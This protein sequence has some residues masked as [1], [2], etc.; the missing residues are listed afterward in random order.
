[1]R[2]LSSTLQ[3]ATAWLLAMGMTLSA[4][5]PTTAYADTETSDAAVEVTSNT[6]TG[7]NGYASIDIQANKDDTSILE[8]KTSNSK[9]TDQ[10]IRL[11]LWEFDEGFFEDYEFTKTPEKNVTIKDINDTKT[12]EVKTKTG[13]NISLEYSIDEENSDYYISFTLEAQSEYEFDINFENISSDTDAIDFV[14]EPEIM[15]A[16]EGDKASD[17]AKL[18]TISDMDS[19]EKSSETNNQSS[20]D[21]ESEKKDPETVKSEEAQSNNTNNLAENNENK[22]G[23]NAYWSLEE[24]EN[25]S[26]TLVISGSGPMYDY[27]L[28]SSEDSFGC[29]S[30]APWCKLQYKNNIA[31]IIIED[32]ITY[33]GDNSF[34]ALLIN[35][36]VI[37]DSVTEIGENVFFA[38]LLDN[39]TL[40]FIGRSQNDKTGYESTFGYLYG[41]MSKNAEIIGIPE[42]QLPN[43]CQKVYHTYEGYTADNFDATNDDAYTYIYNFSYLSSITITKQTEFSDFAFSGINGSTQFNL[44][45]NTSKYSNYM[46][47]SG[48]LSGNLSIPSSVELAPHALAGISVKYLDFSAN[49]SIDTFTH[50]L[51]EGTKTQVLTLPKSLKKI[52]GEGKTFD[53]SDEEG[54][55]FLLTPDLKQFYELD[56]IN[57][58]KNFSSAFYIDDL[59]EVSNKDTD[60][61]RVVDKGVPE[62]TIRIGDNNLNDS[63]IV[64]ITLPNSIV[65]IGENAFKDCKQLQAINLDMVTSIGE[66][67]FAGCVA[68]NY[69][70]LN[71]VLEDIRKETF[72]GCTSLSNIKLPEEIAVIDDGSFY[73]CISLTSIDLPQSVQIIG[74]NAFRGTGLSSVEIPTNVQQIRD[75]AFSNSLSLI[76]VNG[77]NT[78][79]EVRNSLPNTMIADN[80]FYNTGLITNERS[81]GKLFTVEKDGLSV[82]VETDESKNRTPS[83]DDV[84]RLLYYTG[85]TASTNI[86]ISNPNGAVKQSD[87][88]RVLLNSS[89]TYNINMDEGEFNIA[90]GSNNYT[91]K[92]TKT[93]N[94]YTIE[95]EA[96]S[97]G[98]TISF[99][100]GSSFASG[101]TGG[102]L[103]LISAEI[104]SEDGSSQTSEGA[105][106]LSWGTHPDTYPV[107]KQMRDTWSLTGSGNNDGISYI[108]GLSYTIS[109]A[110]SGDTLEGIGEDPITSLTFTDTLSIPEG[111][112]ISDEIKT[113][114]NNGELTYNDKEV[115]FN[116]RTVLQITTDNSIHIESI[117][118]SEDE[119]KLI[120]KW[121]SASAKAYEYILTYGNRIFTTNTKLAENQ[122]IDI[123]NDIAVK[124]S[125]TYSAPQNQ[126]SSV[127]AS[128]T[129]SAGSID[130]SY[131][132][133]INTY[134]SGDVTLNKAFAMGTD[135]PYIITLHNPGITSTYVGELS[136]TLPRQFYISSEGIESMFN[137]NTGDVLEITITNG[138]ITT[139]NSIYDVTGYDGGSYKSTIDDTWSGSQYEGLSQPSKDSYT[140]DYAS[141][142]G[143]TITINKGNDCLIMDYD[144]QKFTIGENGYYKTVEEAF[145]AINFKNTYYTQYSLVWDF[146]N[147]AKEIYSGETITIDIPATAKSSFMMLTK[148]ALGQYNTD[149]PYISSALPCP[150][151][152]STAQLKYANGNDYYKTASV[153]NLYYYMD[154]SINLEMYEDGE[155]V[156]GDEAI[157]EGTVSEYRNYI[158]L[159][160]N[161]KM[162]QIPLVN[163]L[164]SSQVVMV[165]VKENSDADWAADAEIFTAED[166]VQYY[167]I[168]KEGTYEDVY[169][170]QLLSYYGDGYNDAIYKKPLNHSV[171]IAD[172][173][174]VEETGSGLKTTVYWYIEKLEQI[175]YEPME[176]KPGFV[177]YPDALILCYHVLN[178][179]KYNEQN[180]RYY[181][182]TAYLGDYQGHRLVDSFGGV[183]FDIEKN[184]VSEIGDTET[185]S[186][187]SVIGS[188]DTVTYRLS[189][190]STTDHISTVTGSEM[191]DIL[192]LSIDSYRWTKDNV[193]I[194]YSGFES[195]SDTTEN[196][197]TI[198][199]AQGNT[200]QQNIKW[201]DDFKVSFNSP[202][203]IWVTLKYPD[204]TAWEQYLN[205]YS[206]ANLT[207]TFKVDGP[208]N[209]QNTVS[210][211][212]KQ[213]TEVLLQKGVYATGSISDFSNTG[214]KA[215]VKLK[216]NTGSQT[217]YYYPN[218]TSDKAFVAYYVVLYNQG[219]S[220]LYLTD[221]TDTLPEGYTF[222][223]VATSRL[224]KNTM[225]NGGYFTY[226][227]SIMTSNSSLYSVTPNSDN[228]TFATITD[229]QNSA[230]KY[231]PARI[232]TVQSDDNKIT[233][234]FPHN[235]GDNNVASYDEAVGLSY[236]KPGES[237]QFAY[238]CSTDSYDKTQDI[239]NN[240]IAMPIYNRTGGNISI[241][242]SEINVY[243][244]GADANDGG[245]SLISGEE[246]LTK[247]FTDEA[248]DTQWV[249]SDVNV[250]RGGIKPGLSKK[251]VS[252]ESPSA[253]VTNNPIIVNPTDTL[254]WNVT[255]YNSGTN[256]IVD[257]TITDELPSP[258]IFSGD[259]YYNIYG[260]AD[261]V[262]A[263]PLTS[264][265]TELPLFTITN[266]EVDDSG[267][268]ESMTIQYTSA[269]GNRVETELTVGEETINA[270]I[271]WNYRHNGTTSDGSYD[272]T[273]DADYRIGAYYNDKG[274]L[275][276]SVEF[277]GDAMGIPTNGYGVLTLHTKNSTNTYINKTYTNTAYVTPNIQTWDGQV[278]IGNYEESG[279]TEALVDLPSVRNSAPFTVANGYA[280]TSTKS[281]TDNENPTNT[282]TSNSDKNYIVL[283]DATKEFT[284][285]LSVDNVSD[286]TMDKLILIDNLPQVG[287]HD[288]F[289]PEEERESEF[290]VSLSEN[291][292]FVVTVAPDSSSA[293]W[294][295]HTLNS[296]QY[297]IQYSTKTEFNTDD[298][299][300]T[301]TGWTTYQEGAD[302]SEAR[303]IRLI[304]LDDEGTLIPANS[305]VRLSFT[306]K[307]D[308]SAKAGEY[309]WNSF[310]YHYSMYNSELELEA[311]P[312]EVG[313]AIIGKPSIIKNVIDTNGNPST[314]D[315]DATYR[316]ILYKGHY[317]SD[318]DDSSSLKDVA[319][320]LTEKGIEFSYIEL[321]VPAGSTASEELSLADIYVYNYDDTNDFT[322]TDQQW[323]WD[324][325]ESYTLWEIPDENYSFDNVSGGE[326]INNAYTFTYTNSRNQ[327]LECVNELIPHTF[328]IRVN[329]YYSETIGDTTYAGAVEGAVLQVWNADKSEMLDEQTV[330]ETGYVTFTELEAGNYVLVEAEAPEHFVIAEDIAF[331]VNKD[332][333]IT[334]ENSENIE[335]DEKGMFLKMKD[336]MEDG[337][338]IIQKYEDDGET[339]LA[340][341]TY[342]LYDSNDQLVDTK[343]TG[344]DGKVTFT[345]VPFG[346]YTIVET[347]TAEG[348]NLLAEPISVTIPLVMTA[349]DAQAN[350][351]NTTNAFYD[352][353]TDSYIF[354]ALTYNVTDDVTFVLPTTGSNNLAVMAM[355]GIGM[356][357]V[358]AGGWLVYRR[359]RGYKGIINL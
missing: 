180:S 156:N 92:V 121:T 112:Y 144:S 270:D 55:L 275:Q 281:V 231:V 30:T 14:V 5:Q 217:R 220:N 153:T 6:E 314:R 239:S 173:I 128:V 140:H 154:L 125:Y 134:R 232:A 67:A 43:I 114:I 268:A 301:D 284:Y 123:T 240:A 309:A 75:G 265:D 83:I 68:L 227:S 308:E 282:A 97:A 286:R 174:V 122:A 311:A 198:T 269:S 93:G 135:S 233:F 236:L 65:E 21:I 359:K 277:L 82:T 66:S 353:A 332:G 206:S 169:I 177:R 339:P 234:S 352:E 256:G 322:V 219:K 18:T 335:T 17:P 49:S 334:T 348:Y 358:L 302:L 242:D 312:L 254:E 276:L 11:H 185:N 165:P 161:Q 84:D 171:L 25:G 56:F 41:D 237:I 349:D 7:S 147:I 260:S 279:P 176:N 13:E 146:E 102:G 34:V 22:C 337:S 283:E 87:M 213:D 94:G 111:W 346:D 245:C 27:T 40:P 315:E 170:G 196:A 303:S 297:I 307:A 31:Q 187:S 333:M 106:F 116:D 243:D 329:K 287:D 76:E 77:K 168:T 133:D 138:T 71:P 12:A 274:E 345:E 63:D 103:A 98:D 166:G 24:T 188:G 202:A 151:G 273:T 291:P 203:Y 320:S 148:D 306:A 356:L 224:D 215:G 108:N 78:F 293:S 19:K 189:L 136:D 266:I 81:L 326:T 26:Y 200:N 3:K 323:T 57:G 142:N 113:A 46:F 289:N 244:T 118:L 15:S 48:F 226:F 194:S 341:V 109:A 155:R 342:N 110:R 218:S 86:S 327:T 207:N 132:L 264:S 216:F 59:S 143:A 186:N 357:I 324:N 300:G 211:V 32:G 159:V 131:I 197:W 44:S 235:A 16:A 23:E 325:D 8:V 210:H 28:E 60:L 101:S 212:L 205:A 249:M 130:L 164:E 280:T 126:K 89:D 299:A 317:L 1:M 319:E 179:A 85:E 99:S 305:S 347:K 117:L 4:I 90:V 70:I 208:T 296:D 246:A 183:S 139:G 167:L 100:V 195:I 91:G 355:G 149:V 50:T 223:Y 157:T 199:D 51:L 228:Y 178:T 79:E 137:S 263:K 193:K 313:V 344:E 127:T 9:N 42:N 251:L 229:N 175:W 20:S 278:N 124:E 271:K 163:Q 115:F 331:T 330:D 214:V 54:E 241:G 354:F 162:A 248:N 150:Q 204:G 250:Y 181:T 182:N 340:G 64:S 222:E 33:I 272:L 255:A 184:I 285:T 350:N 120:V 253:L 257:Y 290:T 262:I 38:T 141:N 259:V 47:Y 129:A 191:S 172:K 310:G 58:A 10:E 158:S 295:E 258:Y 294:E 292:S 96:P 119:S 35:N 267:K 152:N 29:C 190:Y 328:D 88:I 45:L 261:K 53:L 80:A 304:I 247:G 230:V 61:I 343:T 336:E 36:A 338:I 201:N 145:N 316:F 160:E 225:Y 209:L 73:G 321:N 318:I 2:K 107:S 252:A 52:D 72:K 69:I 39:I 351:A 104:L 221:M 74:S 105:Q 288:T 95:I 62:G 238:V 192:P 298:W 37:P